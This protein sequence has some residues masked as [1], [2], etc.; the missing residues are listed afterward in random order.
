MTTEQ[1][2]GSRYITW[3]VVVGVLLAA[4]GVL[5]NQVN[6]AGDR[7]HEFNEAEIKALRAQISAVAQRQAEAIAERKGQ[8]DQIERRLNMLEARR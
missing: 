5:V 2:N 6:Q 4:L 8:Y 1:R 3:A 7:R